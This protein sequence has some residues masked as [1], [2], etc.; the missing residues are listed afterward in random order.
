[1]SIAANGKQQKR[2][3][4]KKNQGL[5]T[6]AVYP[7]LQK[8]QVVKAPNNG[9][10][11]ADALNSPDSSTPS[12]RGRCIRGRSV[13]YVLISVLSKL[14]FYRCIRGI[15]LGC[16]VR[17]SLVEIFQGRLLLNNFLLAITRLKFLV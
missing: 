1:M 4:S 17:G 8:N 2:I 9:T 15:I 12:I 13:A 3:S 16:E 10:A 14:S 7:I 5:S 11:S 6:A